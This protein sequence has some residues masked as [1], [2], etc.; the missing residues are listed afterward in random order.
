V[1]FQAYIDDSGSGK[2]AFVLSGYIS[3]VDWWE[4][5]SDEW[6][7]ILDE[8]RALKYFKM[9]EAA[10]L[11]KQFAGMKHEDRNKRVGKFVSLI[12]KAAHASIVSVIPIGLFNSLVK[13]NAPMKEFRDPYFVA[14]FDI[15]M[16]I[17]L[18]QVAE[19]SSDT[20]EFI[21]D[22]NPRLAARVPYYYQLTRQLLPPELSRLIAAS[23]RFED[24]KQFLP[25]QAGDLQSWY[26]RRLFAEKIAKEK[27]H[28][29]LHKSLFA[30]LDHVPGL[31]SV[32][33]RAKCEHFAGKQVDEPTRIPTVK[34]FHELLEQ[35]ELE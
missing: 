4:A 23:P 35:V 28:R 6:Q 2:P 20:V 22:D 33:T 29:H 16:K 19:N 15:V 21:F 1:I 17:L 11:S 18:N 9:R 3:S 31:I 24:D 30:Y 13:P 5:F 32:W 26:L 14:L 34:D 8:P 12:R 27:F 25:L 10:N 7:E